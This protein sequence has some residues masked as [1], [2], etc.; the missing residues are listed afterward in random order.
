M[1]VFAHKLSAELEERLASSGA[2]IEAISYGEGALHYYRELGQLVRRYEVGMVHVCFFNYFS[3][4]PWLAWLQGMRL[5]VYEE[6]ISGMLRAVSW[7]RKLL[8]LRTIL[9]ALPMTRVLAISDFVKDELIKRGHKGEQITVRYLGVDEQRFQ[10]DPSARERWLS[11]FAIAPDELLFSTIAVLRAF[12]HP[13]TLLRASA[14]LKQRGVRFRLL[15]AGDGAMLP[16][17]KELSERLGIANSVHWLGYCADPTSLLQASDVFILP[18]VGEAFGLVVP[19]AMACG[20][21]VVGSRSGA[22]PEL[23]AEGQTGLL[24]TP[25]DEVS[26]ADALETLARDEPLRQRMAH[27]GIARVREKFTVD[28][29]VAETM[30]IYE[31]LWSD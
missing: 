7:K 29:Q 22:L 11:E 13:E 8:R 2:Q 1:L 3:L 6:L 16:E 17:L 31:S 5:I 19:E 10:P 27:N 21:P 23:V 30:R 14:L 20:V 24:A 4:I 12:K 9:T 25:R 15:V 26:F 18:S 28:R